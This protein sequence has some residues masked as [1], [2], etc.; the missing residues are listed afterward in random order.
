MWRAKYWLMALPY[1]RYSSVLMSAL[2]SLHPIKSFE[3]QSPESVP[4]VTSRQGERER[5]CVSERQRDRYRER[6]AQEA[7]RQRKQPQT[8]SRG[9]GSYLITGNACWERARSAT[10]T[11]GHRQPGGSEDMISTIIKAKTWGEKDS[12]ITTWIHLSQ[13]VSSWQGR[14]KFRLWFSFPYFLWL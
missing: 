2:L 14:Y 5:V 11:E 3:R 1:G 12:I 7:A 9:P 8:L 10:R 13:N 4:H 6:G